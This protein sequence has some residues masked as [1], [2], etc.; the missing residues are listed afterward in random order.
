M[1]RILYDGKRIIPAPLV[2]ITRNY[3]KS[4]NGEIIG[5]TYNIT[6][7]GTLVAYMGSPDSTGAFYTGSSYPPDEL[8]ANDSRLGAIQRKQEGLRSLFSVEGKQLE[9][10]SS[11]A[12]IPVRCNPRILE[13]TFQE[14]IWYERC[15]YTITLECDSLTPMQEN[16]VTSYISDANEEWSIDT[17]EEHAES[18]GIPKVYS[19][20]HTISANGK[21]FYDE[22]GTLIKEPWEHAKNF[23]LTRLGFSASMV[24]SSGVN[25]I[26]AYYQGLNHVR[27]EQINK[28]GGSYSVTETWVLAS[29]TATENFTVQVSDSLDSPYKQVSI[30][31]QITGYD[32]RDSNLNLLT[33]KYTNAESKWASVS[34]IVYIRAQQFSGYTN[35]NLT[36]LNITIGRNP[37]QGTINYTY[38][39]NTRP[40]TLMPNVRSEVINIQDNIGGELFASVFV[41]GRVPGPVLQP[42][43]TKNANTRSLSIELVMEPITYTDRTFATIQSLI[44]AKP[45]TN[46]SHSGNLYNIIEAANPRNNGFTQVYQDQPQE[47]WDITSFR[48]SYSTNWTYE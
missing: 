39:Y 3:Q 11:I 8:I 42:L 16:P 27:S 43:D 14:G 33:A 4:G 18:L 23:C 46:I 19:L 44:N 22:T 7:T 30:E 40:M 15:D 12:D 35:L 28:Q 47:S 1:A 45:S 34:G 2:S 21:R 6:L 48:Y 24:T 9:I 31:G 10:Q 29:G 25:N 32:Q 41:L 13:I 37:I 38:E 20:S 26:P 36:P 5:T 17:N